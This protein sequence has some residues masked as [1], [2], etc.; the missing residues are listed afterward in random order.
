MAYSIGQFRRGTRAYLM[1]HSSRHALTPVLVRA[2]AMPET[3][4]TYSGT[5]R[6]LICVT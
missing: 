3:E 1:E 4:H 2:F 5:W 6:K